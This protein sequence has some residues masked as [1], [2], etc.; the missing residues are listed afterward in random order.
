LIKAVVRGL[1]AFTQPVGSFWNRLKMNKTITK[2][3]RKI[4]GGNNRMIPV[5]DVVKPRSGKIF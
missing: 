4:N 1:H 2:P 3:M 5:S